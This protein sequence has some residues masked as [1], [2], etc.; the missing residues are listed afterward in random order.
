[1]VII[2]ISRFSFHTQGYIQVSNRHVH[3]GVNA[4]ETFKWTE[5]Y[6]YASRHIES[7]LLISLADDDD[8]DT[9]AILNVRVSRVSGDL[10]LT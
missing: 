5:Q 6:A 4:Y 2:G 7:S 9:C 10:V 3:L 1:M 8:A